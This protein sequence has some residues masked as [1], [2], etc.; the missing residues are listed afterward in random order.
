MS[1]CNQFS[2]HINSLAVERE[3]FKVDRKTEFW[4]ESVRRT[5]KAS[6]KTGALEERFPINFHTT[7][8]TTFEQ[9]RTDVPRLRKESYFFGISS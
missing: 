2:Q 8:G 3:R 7:L 4:F 9:K 1:K 5:N 6:M